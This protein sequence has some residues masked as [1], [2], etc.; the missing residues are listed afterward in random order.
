MRMKFKYVLVVIFIM[1]LFAFVP[2]IDGLVF[3]Y[4]YIAMLTRVGNVN[5]LTVQF[6]QYHLGWLSSDATVII[7]PV[8]NNPN[9]AI[10]LNQHITHGPL[11]KDP[12]SD[13]YVHSVGLIRTVLHLPPKVENLLLGNAATGGIVQITTL[14]TFHGNF[15]NQFMVSPISVNKSEQ[16]KFALQ[17][18]SGIVDVEFPESRISHISTAMT[19][20]SML[21]QNTIGEVSILGLKS[22]GDKTCPFLSLCNGTAKTNIPQ[23]TLKTPAGL[24]VSVNKLNVLTTYGIDDQNNYNSYFQLTLDKWAST[25][26][27]A[28]PINMQFWVNNIN[29]AALI[30]LVDS[31][32]Q[33][34]GK[35]SASD[36][37]AQQL[38]VDQLSMTGAHMIQ[39][40]SVISSD[41]KVN[42]SLGGLSS[43]ARIFWPA[44]TDLPNTI[45]EVQEKISYQI[46]IRAAQ[47]LIA[48]LVKVMDANHIE[49]NIIKAQTQATAGSP[50]PAATNNIEDEV[51]N[52]I[53]QNKV[54][55]D[56]G[57]QIILLYKQHLAPEI[58]GLAMDKLSANGALDAALATQ[59]KDEYSKANQSLAISPDSDSEEATTATQATP[60]VPAENVPNNFMQ[61]Q[62]QALLKLNYIMRDKNE[63]VTYIDR[64]NGV[65]KINGIVYSSMPAELVPPK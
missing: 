40:N 42:T 14:A 1:M 6:T 43:V 60:T 13:R 38:F 62:L 3:K 44:K 39:A 41:I 35:L 18:L 23:I 5:A 36:P 54:S 65:T 24:N 29:S 20:G 45:K 48:Q 51:K 21:L 32:K 7:N 17:G 56:V 46:N 34:K 27:T 53:T 10:T 33:A 11:L 4:K 15:T 30:K 58:F 31:I 49:W 64:Q 25:A 55:D 9:T 16:D 26:S 59:L 61:T 63:F 8:A 37:A 22:S 12:I 19:A 50:L 57:K 47:A 52:W 2:W 28:G